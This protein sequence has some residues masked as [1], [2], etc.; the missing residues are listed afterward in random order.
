VT[1]FSYRGWVI[2]LEAGTWHGRREGT[3]IT[4]ATYLDLLGL[5][6]K[7]KLLWRDYLYLC[8]LKQ[9]GTTHSELSIRAEKG[10]QE[11]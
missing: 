5:L 1:P 7:T 4:A 11:Q 8:W 10:A 6:A 3:T 2:T 9:T